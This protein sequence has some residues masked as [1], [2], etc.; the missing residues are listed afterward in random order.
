MTIVLTIILGGAAL[1]VVVSARRR[2]LEALTTLI[3]ALPIVLFVPQN[4][5]RWLDQLRRD[6]NRDADTRRAVAPIA[7]LPVRNLPLEQ[8]AIA[9]IPSRG[10]FAIVPR[11]H[12]LANHP[13]GGVLTYL[14][15]WLQFQ[16]APRIRVDPARADW[17]ILLDGTSEPLPA[18]ARA[19]YRFGNDVLER[20]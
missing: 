7:I 11:G 18:G 1:A 5:T 6:H 9:S 8:Q 17:L 3:V 4:G 10:T 13:E 16:L 19:V 14:D 12:W 15:S 20:R 2:P